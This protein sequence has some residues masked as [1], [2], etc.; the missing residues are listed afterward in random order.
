MR[1][2]IVASTFLLLLI[3]GIYGSSF[4][5]PT[6]AN[7]FK[8]TYPSSP[9]SSLSTVSGQAGNLCT[10]CHGVSG[11]TR[12]AYGLA[13]AGAGHNFVNIQSAD[14]DNDTFSNLTEINAG[15][16]PGNAAS[17]PATADTTAPAVSLSAP[18]NG[19]S[20]TTAQS[21][22]I[23]ATAS[24]AVGVARVEF[25]DGAT[26]L[27]TDTTSPYSFSW[28]ITSANN[29]SHSLTAK[30]YDAAGNVGTSTA[31]SVTVNI[32]T[33]D[34][35][36][37]A[38][39]LSAPA[40]GASY[41]TAQSVAINAT[42]SDAV[43]VARVE[44][45]DGAT[46]LGTDTTSPYSFSWAIT[47]ANNGS[48]SL[49]AKAYDAAGNVG[50]STAV[51]VTVNIA[52]SLNGAA[53]YATNCEGCHN[54]LASSSKLGRTA[55]QIQTAINNDT[56]GMGFLNTLIPAEISAI[57]AALAPPADTTAP[58]VSLSAPANGASYTTAQS[59]AI[60]ATA[61][62]AV[63]VARVEFYDGA[64]LLGTDTTSPYSFSWAITSAGNGTHSLSA[65]AYDA[66][67]NVGT[68]TAVSVTVNIA[69]A[70]TT[71]PAVSLSAPA[72]GASYTTAQSVAINATASDAVGVARVEFY[73][74]ATL[75]GTDTTSPYSFSW[76]ITSAGNGTHSLSAKAYDAAGNV[77][78]ST[79]VSVT[80]NIA[81]ADTTAPT[82]SL[83]APAN[84]ASYTTAQS[85]AINATAADAVGVAR[86]E[87]YDGATLLGTDTTSPYSF[88]WA[89]TSANNGSHSLTAK[90]YDAAG[91]V[92][93]STAVSVTINIATSLNGAALYATNCEGCHNPLASSS[94]RGE[95]ANEIQ[96]AINENKG[97]MGFLST[98]TPAEISAI[99][100]ALAPSS[101][102]SDRKAPKI[103]LFK[104][105]KKASSL[106][107]PIIA[108][109]A[110][111]DVGVT[112]YR[113]SESFGFSDAD[114]RSTPPSSYTFDGA[115]R[116][117]LYAQ[118][119]D[120]AGNISKAKAARVMIT[121]PS[122]SDQGGYDADSLQKGSSGRKS[123]SAAAPVEQISAY[124]PAVSPLMSPDLSIAQPVAVG[125]V[126]AGGDMLTLQV[127]LADLTS[128]VD[129]YLTLYSPS[130]GGEPARAFT[131]NAD[132][133]FE[134]LIGSKQP[135]RTGITSVQEVISDTP[136]IELMQGKY[137][138]VFEIR[139]P[140]SSEVL[141]T[142]MTSFTIQ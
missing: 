24:D 64:T 102:S 125:S 68:S 96:K 131:L 134:D 8:A 101:S 39:S 49:T 27:G 90:A 107:V 82:V 119:K 139:T 6:Y 32:A 5:F 129:V 51:S 113:V 54:P 55:N 57:A 79:A 47:S 91:N 23:N 59:V 67:G 12:N 15:T 76:A 3:F 61:A 135:W 20:Y 22:A 11:G 4:G 86:V 73:D 122:G 85:V 116:K 60:N 106:Q 36:A 48:H 66:A 14:S 38:V 33:A 92:G 40:N 126:A 84:G 121:L 140:G 94:K 120:A 103:R 124:G 7:S 56:G 74:G 130:E 98:L 13:Y 29:G 110:M 70:D 118:V 128:P 45:Y 111:D 58:T 77:G 26:L 52:T 34:T 112:G 136:A 75:L 37:P 127:A 78:T 108:F 99:A 21:V 43:G 109:T 28:A 41:T 133:N 25:Y 42:A 30:A 87:F 123:S 50:T 17:F 105:P 137:M 83:S 80:V 63:G 141:Y 31:V 44:F 97:G 132:N 62:D 1:R 9:L 53:L 72:N 35:T 69:T 71:A 93:T 18:A 46:L 2:I 10:V 81:A 95:S 115:G 142:W 114:W 104:L 117:V 65:K 16:F 88:S 19:A 100:A 89:I 138:I